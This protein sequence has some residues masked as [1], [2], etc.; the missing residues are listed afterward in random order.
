MALPNELLASDLSRRA[1]SS[2]TTREK[3]VSTNSYVRILVS[4][5][6]VGAS[7]VA[8]VLVAALMPSPSR[9]LLLS[10]SITFA[11]QL[12]SLVLLTALTLARVNFQLQVDRHERY[13]A[14][15]PLLTWLGHVALL[16]TILHV[17]GWG[18]FVWAMVEL[19][20]AAGLGSLLAIPVAIA[21]LGLCVAT[22][23]PFLLLLPPEWAQ[24]ASPAWPDAEALASD[25]LADPLKRKRALLAA[26]RLCDWDACRLLV[27]GAPADTVN[28]IEEPALPGG[29]S[30]GLC[31]SALHY[32]AR[33]DDDGMCYHLLA[34]GADA[35]IVSADTERKN[36]L[37]LA[38]QYGAI[39]ACEAILTFGKREQVKAAL[40]ATDSFAH[41]P[42]ETAES[43]D[44][45]R[46]ATMLAAAKA[47][48]A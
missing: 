12:A 22:C 2:R 14:N 1:I 8:L 36:P 21:A 41:T 3:L 44:N 19:L 35:S 7:F 42:Q 32:A 23:L 25:V 33:Y 4:S 31:W 38:A 13:R 46:L 11:L 30:N 5:I 15:F 47:R 18:V 6:V 43:K 17:L 37:H 28:A 24:R 27:R 9:A 40:L 29:S 45:Y 34:A 16:S 48:L 39:A 20:R 10:L 26:A